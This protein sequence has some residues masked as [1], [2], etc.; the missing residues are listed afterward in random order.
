MTRFTALLLL[1]CL[2]ALA[3]LHARVDL[4]LV[5]PAG[6]VPAASPGHE[7]TL[8]ANNPTDETDAVLRLPAVLTASYATKTSRGAVRFNVVREN[9]VPGATVTHDRDVVVITLK[10]MSSQK[11]TLRLLDALP[12]TEGFVSLRLTNPESN[13]IMFEVVGGSVAPAPVTPAAVFAAQKVQ[14]DEQVKN[15]SGDVDLRSDVEGI[16]R[17]ISGYDPIYFVV[18]ARG[19]VNARFQFSFKYRA[20]EQQADQEWIRDLYFAYTQTSIWDLESLSKPFYD[21]SYKPTIFF[22]RERFFDTGIWSHIG[23]QLGAQ[24]ESNGKGDGAASQASASGLAASTTALRHPRDTR[25]LNTLYI[26]PKVRWA[27]RDTGWFAEA[28]VRAIAYFQIDENP[29]LPNY[30]GHLELLFRGGQDRGGQLTI[31][32]RGSPR[33]GHGSAEFNLTWPMTR[34][35]VPRSLI[36]TD[37]RRSGGGYFQ[38]Q[39]FNGYGESL[40]DYD[41]RRKDQLRLGFEIV[42]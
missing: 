34:L 16:R 18:G 1:V 40:L 5:P 15:G 42:R 38:I 17:H 36:P 22:L 41:V 33:H 11:I 14:A 37:L 39:Y 9:A 3:P 4:L 25:S 13:T 27:S 20:F 32:L 28:S 31:L 8:Y 7:L 2:L 21:S 30:R 19:R 12:A 35:P 23:L 10:E 24:H 26:A 29:D 6:P